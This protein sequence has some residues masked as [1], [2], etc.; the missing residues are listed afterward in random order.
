MFRFIVTI[1]DGF[2]LEAAGPVF[3]AGITMYSPLV[4]WKVSHLRR[5]RRRRVKVVNLISAMRLRRR[6]G[7]VFRGHISIYDKG[8]GGD[9]GEVLSKR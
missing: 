7:K 6:R 8:S 3:C 1:P 4:H 9:V 2:P 5:R